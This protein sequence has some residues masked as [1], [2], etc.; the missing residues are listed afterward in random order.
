MKTILI[1]SFIMFAFMFSVSLCFTSLFLIDH[2]DYI[3]TQRQQIAFVSILIQRSESEEM[4][5]S[6]SGMVARMI[7]KREYFWKELQKEVHGF[8]ELAAFSC[9]LLFWLLGERTIY[10]YK[11]WP[12][13]RKGPCCR[14]KSHLRLVSRICGVVALSVVCYCAMIFFFFFLLCSLLCPQMSCHAESD[15]MIRL[16]QVL[17]VLDQVLAYSKWLNIAYCFL[18]LSVVF[19]A[20]VLFLSKIKC[21]D[22]FKSKGCDDN[23]NPCPPNDGSDNP[24]PCKNPCDN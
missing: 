19:T 18:A 7:R 13:F 12:F 10:I 2:V 23:G 15:V 9:L 11:K 17:L 8:S 5:K 6:A 22:S 20:S 16:E 21:S 24:K 1:K 14:N 4:R 3:E